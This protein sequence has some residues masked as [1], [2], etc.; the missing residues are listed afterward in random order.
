MLEFG[1]LFC[2]CLTGMQEF[3]KSRLEQ[4]GGRLG[5]VRY[6]CVNGICDKIP[7]GRLST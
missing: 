1:C 7:H 6:G 4:Q 3:D 5:T 2:N